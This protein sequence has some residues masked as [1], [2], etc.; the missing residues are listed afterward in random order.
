MNTRTLGLLL[1]AGHL[2]FGTGLLLSADKP[3]TNSIGM[4]FVHLSPG[5]FMMGQAGPSADYQMTKHPAK[6]DDAEADEKPVHAV[7]LTQ[8]FA[9]AVTEVTLAQYRQFEPD[10]L[11]TRG[12]ATDAAT[13]VSWSDA[14]A[15]CDWLSAKENKPYRLPTE[16]EWEYACRAGT[17]TLFH[18]GDALPPGFHKWVVD[19]GSRERYFKSDP[20]PPEYRAKPRS[21]EVLRTRQTP[22]NAWGLYDMHGNAAEWCA[23]W[24]GPYTASAKTNPLGPPEADFRVFRGGHHSTFTRLLRS[25]NRGAWLPDSASDRIG[26]RVVMGTLPTGEPAPLTPP[27]LNAESVSQTIPPITPDASATPFFAGPQ[28]YVLIPPE[29]YGPL[30][31]RHNHSPSITECPNGDLLAVWYSCAD[32]AGSELSNVASRLRYG[33][34]EWEPASVFWDGADINDHAPKV[35]WD[36]DETLYFFA[37]G[38]RE[39]IIRTS[40]DNGATWSRARAIQPPGEFGN[41]LLRLTDG[42]LVLGHDSRQTS[43][44]FSHDAG[45]TWASNDLQ[46]R[47]S[48]IRPGSTGLRY[49]GIH[50]PMVQLTD[51]RIMALSRNDPPEDQE[52]FGFK[53]PVSYS[54]D[55]GKTWTYDTSAFPAISI[56]QRAAMLR[57]KNKSH[58]IVVFSFTDQW[59]DWKNR[60]GMTFKHTSGEFQ[61]FGLFAAVSYD[62]GKT[63]PVRRLITPGGTAREVNTID[64]VQFTMSDNMAEPCGY[65]AATQTRDHRIHLITS[66]NHYVLNLAWLEALPANPAQ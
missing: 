49:P 37:R 13:G 19:L 57:L 9:M 48:D 10:H 59:R 21:S 41:Q 23:D 18:T 1:G 11:G 4:E 38:L 55:L 24:Y 22:P 15:F 53:T 29:S 44:V 25:A 54:A 66:K 65:L 39:N 60:K 6:F 27:P 16:A 26:F 33:T 2:V 36:G 12:A 42:T 17:T 46:K 51:G 45:Q 58:P 32:E 28:P 35:W 8:P 64:R 5:T 52:K 63:W 3:F 20:L 43:L 34:K 30:F 47:T 61:G 40:K 7:T 31:T 62:E 14:Q 50:A 56:V